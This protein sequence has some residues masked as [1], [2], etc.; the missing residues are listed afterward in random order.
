MH[1]L[2]YREEIAQNVSQRVKE[3]ENGNFWLQK[4]LPTMNILWVY[5]ILSGV[6]GWFSQLQPIPS[7]NGS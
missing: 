1:E 7:R 5:L 6:K 3:M 2:E 4:F